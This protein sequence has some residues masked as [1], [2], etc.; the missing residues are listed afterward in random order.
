MNSLRPASGTP[1]LT[2]LAYSLD[3]REHPKWDKGKE[4]VFDIG[5]EGVDERYRLNDEFIL[6]TLPL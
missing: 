5:R 4:G 3:L 6:A 1:L 2:P